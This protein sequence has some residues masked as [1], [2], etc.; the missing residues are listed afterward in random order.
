MLDLL[1]VELKKLRR[2]RLIL[3]LPLTSLALPSIT[4][5]YFYKHDTYL[6][7][8]GLYKQAIFSFN[9][10]FILP[11]I[12]GVFATVL[13]CSEYHY[14]TIKQ[15]WLIPVG[16]VKLIFA[17]W[18]TVLIMSMLFMAVSEVF[19]FVFGG[20][21]HFLEFEPEALLFVILKGAQASVIEAIAIF[22]ILAVAALHHN[23]LMPCCATIIYTFIGFIF[24]SVNPYLLP[25]ASAIFCIAHDFPNV[26]YPHEYNAIFTFLCFFVWTV[27]SLICVQRGLSE[28]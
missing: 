23:Y 25:S 27:A 18:I 21:F 17:K 10:F 16:K 14:T 5:F 1:S 9:I 7:D 26:I 15:L 4:F 20:I 2:R 22:P 24:A 6:T 11:V 13:V 3:L 8:M 28:R 19:T 12:L